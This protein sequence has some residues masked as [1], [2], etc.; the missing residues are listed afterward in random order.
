[1]SILNYNQQDEQFQCS[2]SEQKMGSLTD[3]VQKELFGEKGFSVVKNYVD[4]ELVQKILK[5]YP[6]K[7]W[8]APNI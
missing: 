5:Y 4:P 6:N 3:T 8:C 2:L 7:K 1:M